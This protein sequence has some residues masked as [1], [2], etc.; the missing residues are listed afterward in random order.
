MD[1]RDRLRWVIKNQTGLWAPGALG[2]WRLD[3]ALEEWSKGRPLIRALR[4]G[5][6][7]HP[8]EDLEREVRRC[9]PDQARKTPPTHDAR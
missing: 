8:L 7:G 2:L 9:Y 1:I 6:Y 5:F 4:D 3:I